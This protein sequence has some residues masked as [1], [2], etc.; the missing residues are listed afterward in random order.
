M[1]ASTPPFGAN[2]YSPQQQQL[3]AFGG[4]S[5][6]AGGA[7]QRHTAAVAAALAASSGAG[8]HGPGLRAQTMAHLQV[9]SVLCVC[10]VY[11]KKSANARGCV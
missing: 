2:P 1:Q 9:C 8:G 5:G 10:V 11:A 3:G 6:A 7:G 4:I